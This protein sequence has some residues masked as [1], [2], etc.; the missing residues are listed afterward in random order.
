M[1]CRR[2]PESFSFIH[3]CEGAIARAV[4]RANLHVSKQTMEEETTTVF[5]ALHAT[6]KGHTR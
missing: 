5:N 2:S 1:N 6:K 3:E 4:G